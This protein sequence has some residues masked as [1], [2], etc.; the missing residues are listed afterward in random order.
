MNNTPRY[1]KMMDHFFQAHRIWATDIISAVFITIVRS[2]YGNED[3]DF[4][5]RCRILLTMVRRVVLML[6]D[7][8]RRCK[9]YFS[10]VC[11]YVVGWLG[12]VIVSTQTPDLWWASPLSAVRNTS[13]CV[14]VGYVRRARVHQTTESSIYAYWYP[15]RDVSRHIY[16][17]Y[18]PSL[19]LI[20][21]TLQTLKIRSI[22][23]EIFEKCWRGNADQQW[24]TITEPDYPYRVKSQDRRCQK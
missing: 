2:R 16:T 18:W 20:R 15:F 17:E 7:A 1:A 12:G 22:A 23:E 13:L 5:I 11:A 9:M 19:L 4:W 10:T 21:I 3:D 8:E 24:Q 6:E 14:G